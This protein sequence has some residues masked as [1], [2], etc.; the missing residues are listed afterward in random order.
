MNIRMMSHS[1]MLVQDCVQQALISPKELFE[2]VSNVGNEWSRVVTRPDI[3]ANVRPKEVGEK[4]ERLWESPIC[5]RAVS[6]QM[7]L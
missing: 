5:E 7:W 6:D 4:S 1:A 3:V 2:H